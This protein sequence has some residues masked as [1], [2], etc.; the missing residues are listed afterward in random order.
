MFRRD[1]VGSH[2]AALA[3]L[4]AG[5][6]LMSQPNAAASP[7]SEDVPV[8]G[9][10]ASLAQ[11][12]GIDPVPD[13]ARF[14]AEFVRVLY[15][16]QERMSVDSKVRR[17]IAYLKTAERYELTSNRGVT[18]GALPP[19]E[20]VPIPLPAAVWAGVLRRPVDSAGLFSAV[21]SDPAAALLVHGLAALDDE[22][23]R[24]FA[25]H[26]AVVRRLHEDGAS[27]FAVFAAHLAVHDNR[28]KPPG[29]DQAVPLW[30]ALLGEK[31]TQ[32][33]R[34]IRQ[35]FTRDGGR[36]AYLYDTI[37][38]VD[39][40]RAAFALGLWIPDT[41]V[42]LDRF[43]ALGSGMSSIAPEWSIEK[44]PFRRPA[45]DL[46]S[47][48]LRVHVTQNGSPAG[49]AWR[50]LW[51][52]TF[53]DGG[54]REEAGR[55]FANLEKAELIDAAWLVEILLRGVGPS[56][57]ER[58]DLFAF[59]QRAFAS[60]DAAALADALE[61]LRAFPQVRMLTLTLE[62]IGVRRPA[63]YAALVRQAGR[64]SDL[65]SVRARAT[66]AQF[67]SAIALVERL[68]RV[69]TIDG[70]TADALLETLAAVPLQGERGYGGALVLWLQ[71]QL[72]P[73]LGGT[74][75]LDD[76]LIE[77]L[78]G[79]RGTIS[80]EPVS[81]E[82]QQY[83]L[84][85]VTSELQRLRRGQARQD[86]CP[87]DVALELHAIARQAAMQ[88][89]A[90]KDID[91]TLA[92]LRQLSTLPRE[93]RDVLEKTIDDITKMR[94]SSDG[95][96]ASRVAASL[97][98][99]VDV[100][101]GESMLS[102]NYEVN[103][104]VPRGAR[105][106]AASVAGRHDFG[107]FQVAYEQ[108]VRTAWAMPR[109]AVDDGMP[110]HVQGAALGLDLAIPSLAL[111]RIHTAPSAAPPAI[112]PGE[113]DTF[114]ASVA[115]MNP[116]ALRN[117]DLAAIAEAV[118]RGRRR[119]DALTGRDDVNALA[120]EI[121]MDG[122]RL[123]ALQ[124][125]I[126]HA[127]RSVGSLFSMTDLLYLGGGGRLDLDAWGMSAMKVL[128]CLCTRVAAPGLWT[129]LIGR[130]QPGLLVAAVADVNLRVAVALAEMQLPAAL[131]RSLL[132]LA[133][134]DFVDS[135]QIV[136]IDD[137]LARI[138]TAQGLTRE[139]VEDYVAVVTVDGPLMP[140]DSASTSDRLP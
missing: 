50:R 21:M 26:P 10:I 124:W 110:W 104:E 125:S 97:F 16:P 4:L 70:E 93:A 80:V 140:V 3:G 87:I 22:T 31:T 17:F 109:R 138:Q 58:L 106:A 68:T 42:R 132:A 34:F 119:V 71:F 107:L 27:A 13:R 72:R 33:D 94:R 66:L 98:D 105:W 114:A 41:T 9:G 51:A 129:V 11:A 52:Q 54:V 1:S 43:Q 82:G 36:L 95:N 111:R 139:R 113:R 120:R 8:P 20:R 134:Q 23:L 100:V 135:V 75:R 32:P 47:M 92:S 131:A 30:E 35:L 57:S 55:T 69:R 74:G 12:I 29:G 118:A 62:R 37:G 6:V 15:E 38:S 101:L 63:L 116:V 53:D 89:G 108:R 102:L 122:W 49:L 133:V 60:I 103:L 137:W 64:M 76:T 19:V 88:S 28:V 96:R 78:A 67:Q 59:G 56:R 40:P 77:A 2:Q 127:P 61:V 112:D 117:G 45:H 7:V 24:F 121:S 39:A 44:F 85:L 86:R 46:A 123:R 81:W 130:L 83:E 136:H 84:D 79:A 99:L 73:A 115:L 91:S 18:F 90:A 65:E 128:G 14:A 48:L 5:V 126:E 25:D